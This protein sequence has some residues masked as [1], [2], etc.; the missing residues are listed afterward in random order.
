MTTS[1]ALQIPQTWVDLNTL[2]G[3]TKG[4]TL[5]VQNVGYPADLIEIYFSDS[6]PVADAKGW[7]LDQV[8][9]YYVITGETETVWARFFKNDRDANLY[10][11]VGYLQ[12]VENV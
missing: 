6:Q 2:S 7:V 9:E 11:R 10:S 5:F 8:K 12:V 1:T 3:I 4:S